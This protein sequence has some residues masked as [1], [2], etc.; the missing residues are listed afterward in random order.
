MLPT[1]K[2]IKSLRNLTCSLL[3]CFLLANPEMMRWA[4]CLK[5]KREEIEKQL[6]GNKGN[7][8]KSPSGKQL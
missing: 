5:A 3:C 6:N 1:H 4:V 2:K 8:G 7:L